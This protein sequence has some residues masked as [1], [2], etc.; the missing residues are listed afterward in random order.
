M[1][2]GCDV[3]TVE[4][5]IPVI[6][7]LTHVTNAEAVAV[8]AIVDAKT[9]PGT[10]VITEPADGFDAGCGGTDVAAAGGLGIIDNFPDHQGRTAINVA[11]PPAVIPLFDGKAGEG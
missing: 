6:R 11:V 5:E 9:N 8:P 2:N 4:V 10:A 1:A 3:L 7:L